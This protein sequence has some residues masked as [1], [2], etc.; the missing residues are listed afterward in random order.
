MYIAVVY[1]YQLYAEWSLFRRHRKQQQLFFIGWHTACLKFKAVMLMGG[2]CSHLFPEALIMSL[3]KLIAYSM[4]CVSICIA[5]VIFLLSAQSKLSISKV[6]SFP[7]LDKFLH[8]CAFGS[9]AFTLSYWFSADKWL[10]KPLKYFAIVCCVIA[11]YGI[12]D[13][14]HQV[15]VPGRDASVYDWFADCVG[16]ILAL[17]LRLGIL[18]VHTLDLLILGESVLLK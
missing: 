1:D 16:A 13:E 14:M 2:V 9:L 12:T 10:R 11:C 8:A 6:I 17:L 4:R 3:E 18:K 7:C 5:V 15:F